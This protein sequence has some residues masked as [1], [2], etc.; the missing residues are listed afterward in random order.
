MIR[1]INILFIVFFCCIQARS[2]GASDTIPFVLTPFNNIYVKAV[3]NEVDTLNLMFH[4]GESGA[5][6]TE[7]AF[8]RI[9]KPDAVTS[10]DVESWGGKG[11]SKILNNNQLQIGNYT[12]D[13]LEIWVNKRSGR[14]TDGKF[15]PSLFE[16]KIIELDYNNHLFIVHANLDKKFYKGYQKFKLI[17]QN[18]LLFIKGK[19]NIGQ[20][21]LTQLFMIHTG[22][23]GN[24]LIDDEF[25]KEHA[26]GTALKIVDK[27][28]LKDSYGNELVTQKATLPAFKIGKHRLKDISISFF[29]GA[30]GRQKISVLGNGVLKQFNSILDIDKGIIYL[31]SV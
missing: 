17:Q 29:S 24:V 11:E 22:Y 14:L 19:L 30:I 8:D 23:G 15:G 28:I 9:L 6:I 27:S 2:Q 25:A 1:T 12:F 21:N 4:T 20:K 26:L 16:G 7:E 18:G 31:K 10:A 13:D 5:T 3:L